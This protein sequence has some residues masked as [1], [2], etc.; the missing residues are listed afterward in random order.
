MVRSLDIL[1]FTILLQ[2]D[3]KIKCTALTH[4]NR[5]SLGVVSGVVVQG[6]YSQS[7]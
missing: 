6:F 2:S 4:K 1:S 3:K 5:S 7:K